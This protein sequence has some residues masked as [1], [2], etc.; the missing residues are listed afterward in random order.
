MLQPMRPFVRWSSVEIRRAN[1][2]GFTAVL[3]T[4]NVQEAIALAD[5]VLGNTVSA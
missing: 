2:Q 5:R 3:V 4:H 1:V